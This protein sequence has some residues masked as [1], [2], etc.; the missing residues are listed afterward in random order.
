MSGVFASRQ[1]PFFPWLEE[2]AGSTVLMLDILRLRL[3]G[4]MTRIFETM[5]GIIA[6]SR[7]FAVLNT[8]ENYAIHIVIC[9]AIVVKYRN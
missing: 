8:P 3:R 9:V 1:L 2:I 4:G 6:G 5:P 7:Q